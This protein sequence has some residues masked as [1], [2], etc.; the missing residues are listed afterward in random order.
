MRVIKIVSVKTRR[1]GSSREAF[2]RHYEEQHVPLGLG[3][4]DRFRWRKYVRNHVIGTLAGRV[5]FDCL[6]E[7]WI[8]S[9]EDQAHTGSFVAS[10]EF[11]VL[12]EDDRRFLDVE[13]RLSFEVEEARLSGSERSI[14]PP[15]TRRIALLF[16]RAAGTPEDV[17]GKEVTELAEG[18]A[19]RP[20]VPCERIL[21]D[22]R[23]SEGGHALEL[24]AT[25]SFWPRAEASPTV[26]TGLV[27]AGPPGLRPFACVD[28][29]VVETPPEALW[30]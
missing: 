24:A 21:L 17:F 7:F 20:P 14:D 22:R 2:R 29:E 16:S 18:I 1:P 30:R 25:L 23:R 11:R 13:R 15:G 26:W 4:I 3:F 27:D 5:E 9:P 6:T 12:D 19:S 10:P 8:A 28:L